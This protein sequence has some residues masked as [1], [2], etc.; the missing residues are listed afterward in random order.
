[1]DEPRIELDLEH[2]VE[3]GNSAQA[4]AALREYVA[5]RGGV[6]APVELVRF[7]VLLYCREGRGRHMVDFVDY[8]VE[9]GTLLW[10]RPGQVQR[11]DLF[12]GAFDASLVVFSSASVAELPLFDDCRH[13]A[14]VALGH[15]VERVAGLIRWVT[16]EVVSTVDD[17]VAP[18]LIG[19]MLRLFQRVATATHAGVASSG[20]EL[21]D[22]YIASVEAN[23][24]IR[25]VAWHA[26]ELGASPRTLARATAEVLG[27]SPKEIID[28]HVVLEA[29]RQLAWSDDSVSAVARTLQ[30][31]EASN[32]T[33][34]FRDRTGIAPSAFRIEHRFGN[35]S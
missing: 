1:M 24:G 26:R 16:E 2:A 18:A 15:E 29:Q 10:V 32:F 30:F 22:R 33:R 20:Q 9:A 14:A 27:R 17:G 34:F 13:V 11:W 19:V 25:S 12:D 31:S 23:V 4:R 3:I 5:V 6:A 8:E 28:R 7:H 21:V 35:Q